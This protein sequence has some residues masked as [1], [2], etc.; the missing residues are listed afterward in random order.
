MSSFYF[1]FVLNTS[2]YDNL[3]CNVFMITVNETYLKN[4]PWVEKYRPNQYQDIILEDVNKQI[5]NTILK[6]GTFPN[7]LLY[8]PP[9]TGKTTTIMNI[10]KLFLQKFYVFGKELIV[11]LNASDE[12][13]IDIIRNQ[14]N[15]FTKTNVLFNKGVK[16]I[17][18]DEADYMTKNAQQSLRTI[19]HERNPNIKF[20]IICN[21]I[22]KIEDGL[23]H[24][25]IPIRFN[26]LPRQPIHDLLTRI[27]FH[28][29]IHH[30]DEYINKI[31][32]TYNSDI[33]SM[34]NYIQINQSSMHSNHTHTVTPI[35]ITKT[36]LSIMKKNIIKMENTEHMENTEISNTTQ[37]VYEYIIDICRNNHINIE[38]Y[39][40]S[41]CNHLS[42]NHLLKLPDESLF[43]LYP[44][45]LYTTHSFRVNIEYRF[46]FVLYHLILSFD[47]IRDSISW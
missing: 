7:I 12:R 21:Y 32:D 26:N 40:I 17:I 36:I 33:R 34:I 20:C 14:I 4:I 5:F 9:G 19:I 25:F 2:Q 47:F 3:Y 24:E 43:R 22:S 11:H 23:K 18:L 37:Y 42:S 1:N 45:L 44:F 10:T 27:C 8:G 35:H 46:Y 29:Q 31:I 41:F 16:F 6:N 39:F 15:I 30:H 13:G 38:D 28:E